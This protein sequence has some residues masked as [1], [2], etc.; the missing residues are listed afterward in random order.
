MVEAVGAEVPIEILSMG[1]WLAGHAL[2]AQRFR[3]GRVFLAGDAAHLFTPLG[4]ALP[5][6]LGVLADAAGTTAALIALA[7][8]PVGLAVIAAAQR[9]S[10]RP[11]ASSR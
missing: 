11:D 3:Q 1:T 2:V 6:L 7:A 9:R 10:G 5:W 4:L 8:Q